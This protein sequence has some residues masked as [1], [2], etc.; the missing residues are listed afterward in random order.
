MSP[1]LPRDITLHI[2]KV[3]IV[4]FDMES[5]CSLLKIRLRVCF[6]D[7]HPCVLIGEFLAYVTK[8]F[9]QSKSCTLFLRMAISTNVKSDEK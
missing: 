4:L 5:P 9:L 2:Y 7:P 6:P 3:Y 8:A 1:A